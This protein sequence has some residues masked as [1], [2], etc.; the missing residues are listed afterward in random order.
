MD[1]ERI[2]KVQSGVISPRLSPRKLRLKLIGVQR[3][4]KA[5]EHV[6]AI[7]SST[8]GSDKVGL[9]EC[10]KHSLLSSESENVDDEGVSGVEGFQNSKEDVN[11]HDVGCA[12]QTTKLSTT[13]SVSEEIP[14]SGTAAQISA[15]LKDFQFKE[16]QQVQLKVQNFTKP[17]STQMEYASSLNF[18]H[19]MRSF[20]DDSFD[21]DSGHENGSVS[22]FEFHKVDRAPPRR[23]LGPHSK[24]APSKWDDAEKWLVNLSSGDSHARNKLK[25]GLGY[26]QG[27]AVNHA[28]KAGFSGQGGRQIGNASVLMT[29]TAS[30]ASGV[31]EMASAGQSLNQEEVETKK[32]YPDKCVSNLDDGGPSKFAF[33]P[34]VA[35]ST[36]RTNCSLD[37]YSLEDISHSDPSGPREVNDGETL[38]KPSL[39]IEKPIADPAINLSKHDPSS[40]QR[41]TPSYVPPPSTVRSVS[42]RDM[43]TEMTPIASQEPSRTGTPV[44]ATTPTMRSPNSSR[45]S[46]PGR[47]APSSSPMDITDNEL[48]SQAGVN[49][50]ELSEKELHAKTRR[51]IIALGTKLGKANIAAWA[52]KQEEEDKALKSL[53]TKVPEP[54]MLIILEA[55]ATAWEEAE[56]AKYMARY[57]SEEV[58]IQAWENHQKAKA[59]AEM[60]RIEVKVERIRGHAHEK[61]MNKLAAARHR[62][63]ERLAAAEAKRSQQAAKTA[64]RAE[65]IRQTGHMPSPFSHWCCL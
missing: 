8:E 46:T 30:N 17:T 48:G 40:T 37:R 19:A 44:R 10:A 28:R 18:V 20:E 7:T 47:V 26:S 35:H 12:L 32:I 27:M 52:S 54:N 11:S 50:S 62:A 36:A 5:S 24:P 43:G 51:E 9:A 39:R 13:P 15:A 25:P 31:T 63:E 61:L 49:T 56:K 45:P 38:L 6:S 65:Y 64:Q 41:T 2:N 55:R 3:G 58:K 14:N 21:Y 34:S 33:M 29:K 16:N 53:E 60:K 57:K 22:S 4:W 1:Y 42:M 59:E 23:V